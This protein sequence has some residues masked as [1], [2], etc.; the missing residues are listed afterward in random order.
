MKE[1]T[2]ISNGIGLPE[3]R[4]T[5]CLLVA[6]I[7]TF[8]ICAKGVQSTGKASYFL[9]LF[10]YVILFALLIRSVT[11]EGAGTGILYFIEPKWEM[12]LSAN[13]SSF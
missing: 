3:W 9:A 12:L 4:L 5:L 13:V 8:L 2:D 1:S 6:W 11:L 7:T 10:P